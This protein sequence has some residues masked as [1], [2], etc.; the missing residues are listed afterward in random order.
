VDLSADVLARLVARN[1]LDPAAVDDVIWGCVNQIGD[2]SSNVARL[3]ILAAGWPESVPGTTLDRACGSSQQAVHFA[4]ATIMAGHADVVI[5]GGVESMTRVPLGSARAVGEPMGPRVKARYGLDEFSQGLGAEA[6][7]R[8]WNLSREE[9][10]TYALKSHDRAAAA[11]DAGAFQGQLLPMTGADGVLESDEGIRR[12]GSLE[13]LAA[14]KPSFDPEGVIH[15]G[16]SSQISDGCAALLVMAGEKA[17]ALGLRPLARFHSGAVCG[18]DPVAMVLGPIPATA[19]VLSRAGLTL[20]E[21]GIYEVN[22][23]FAPVPMVWAT[24]TGADPGRVNPLGGAIAVGHPLGASGAILMTR[25]VH[26][27]NDNG[28]RYGLQ[29]MCERGGMAN[30]TI[31]E[32][33]P[34]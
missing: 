15:A 19:R 12:D 29:A 33:L 3:A 28:I 4:A 14:L 20:D 30:A 27:M 8:R 18:D 31:L 13:R 21:I 6:V 10:D 11:T 24:E 17:A 5:A 22:E 16:N 1:D 23:A 2:Q 25:L 9:L 7:A 34:C 32:L 26:H